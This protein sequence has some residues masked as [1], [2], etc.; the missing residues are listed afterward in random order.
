MQKIVIEF[1]ANEYGDRFFHC[2]ILY[3]MDSGMARIFSYGTPRDERLEEHPLR[4]LTNK[5]N[6]YFT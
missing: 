6:H 3:H 5:S 1:D 2:H 4:I